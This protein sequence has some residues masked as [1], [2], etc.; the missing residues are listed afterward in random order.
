MKRLKLW[1]MRGKKC[2]H[3]CLW[4]RYFSVCVKDFFGG[5]E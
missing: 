5:N 3:C 2:R 1:L 4:C